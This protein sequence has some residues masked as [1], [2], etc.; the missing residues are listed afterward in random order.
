MSVELYPATLTTQVFRTY[1]SDEV[2]VQANSGS[3]S[4]NA[5]VRNVTVTSNVAFGNVT[6]NVSNHVIRFSGSYTTGYADNVKYTSLQ[7]NTQNSYYWL[8]PSVTIDTFSAPANVISWSN[9]SSVV[10]GN[11]V[12]SNT[13]TT[14][15]VYVYEINA[16]SRTSLTFTYNLDIQYSGGGANDNVTITRAVTKDYMAAYTYLSALYP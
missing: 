11:T 8:T 6:I 3:S 1:F 12:W 15:N 2:W 16:D 13:S 9:T 5:N 14:Y 10:N 4:A 7:S